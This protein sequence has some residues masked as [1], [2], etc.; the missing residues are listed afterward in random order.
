[1]GVL[2]P[3][4]GRGKQGWGPETNVYRLGWEVWGKGTPVLVVFTYVRET[5]V[6]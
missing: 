4:D 2:G 6:V 3:R 5:P 1:M